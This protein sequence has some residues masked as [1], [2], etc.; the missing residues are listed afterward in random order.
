MK[1]VN[2]YLVGYVIFIIGVDR[3]ARQDGRA[4]E[5]G[6]RLDGHR[7]RHRDRPR[8]HVL[9]LGQ[10]PEGND[11]DRSALTAIPAAFPARAAGW[12]PIAPKWPRARG[13]PA[14]ALPRRYARATIGL[15]AP[16]SP[17][18]QLVQ[19]MPDASPTKW[20]L[21]H[22]TWFF[23]TFVLS[24]FVPGYRPVDERYAYLFN[25]YYEAVGPR[26]PRPLRGALTRPS[27]DEVR[28][29]RDAIDERMDALLG[30]RRRTAATPSTAS[31]WASSTS[32]ST[33]S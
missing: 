16:L 2:V 5:G 24:R 33:R 10:R 14:R 20:H 25:S 4:R 6:H 13:R 11:R 28:A 21:A 26:Q 17:E 30:W 23:E 19:S 31:S 27:L 9:D 18:D 7:R 22:T 8:R 15:A 1:W 32:S 29:Y 12:R 3:R